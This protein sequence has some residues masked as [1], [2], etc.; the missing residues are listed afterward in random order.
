MGNRLTSRTP[1]DT[2]EYGHDACDE[3]SY[4]GDISYKF[5]L[6]GRLISEYDST[7]NTERT[8]TWNYDDRL[9]YINYPNS[10]KSSMKYDYMGLRTYRKDNAG[11]ITNYYWS[12]SSLPQVINETDGSGN[13]KASYILGAGL[14][15]IKVSGVKKYSLVFG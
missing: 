14:I 12:L 11:D 4:A 1:T 3:M 9:L 5:D 2:T 10:T 6:K 13:P 15:A 8:Y 7:D